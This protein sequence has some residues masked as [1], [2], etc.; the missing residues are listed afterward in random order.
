VP[1]GI[2]ISTSPAAGA[3]V[4]QGTSVLFYLSIGPLM[5]TVPN[6]VGMTQ[7]NAGTA[8]TSAGL[9]AGTITQAYS[10]TVA[11][12]TVI[13]QCPASG[14]SVVLGTAV[15]LTV[16]QGPPPPPPQVPVPNVAG[17]P[18]ADAKAAVIAAGLN[19]GLNLPTYSFTVPSGI[20]I[21]TSPAAGASVAQGTSVLFYLSIGPQMVTVP[22]VAGMTTADAKSA[23]ISAGLNTGLVLPVHSSTVPAG[24][25]ISTSP[26][27]GASVVIGSSVI[28]TASLG[29]QPIP[30]V[31]VP[32]VAGMTTADAKA[33][34]IAAGLNA[35]L[36]LPV[37]HSSTVPAG[38]VIS[39][40]PAAGASVAQGTSVLFY[41]SIGPLMVTVPN[42]V[43][44]TTA[45]AKSAVISAGLN[46][47]LVLSVNSSTVPAGIVVRQAPVAGA[48]V[49][50][51]TSVL[52]YVSIGPQMVT[53]PN[54]VGMT[55][56][57]AGTAITSAGLTTG[58][59]TQAY[60][61][62]VA[63]G[64]VI[65]QSPASGTSVVSGTAVNLTVSQGPQP[66]PMVTVPNVAG[67]TTANAKSAVISAGLNAGLVLSFHSPTVPAGRVIGTSPAAGASVAQ[68]TSVLFYVSIGP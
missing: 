15:D 7:A 5:V 46:A 25:V 34:V 47:G 29:P 41:V 35:G 22:N 65:S 62:T 16:S 54:V 6:V 39:T 45:D 63:S 10:D 1:A 58:T 33:A 3:S 59:I 21:S 13:N 36:V 11:S 20:V 52:F 53:V 27:A 19:A 68:G 51:G 14:T 49:V 31:T 42:V 66:I 32:N 12:G 50:E 40:S 17:M 37:V 61:S 9:T 8:I 43:G 4:A 60:S 28:F 24:I 2:V 18:I 64:N 26:A 38:S 67:M 55:Q 44:M 57:N 30:M 48:S 56:A 23:V